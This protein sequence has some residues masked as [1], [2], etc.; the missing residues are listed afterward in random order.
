[1][2]KTF[3][4]GLKPANFQ[5]VFKFSLFWEILPVMQQCQYGDL[6]FQLAAVLKPNVSTPL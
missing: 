3:G 4:Y 2:Y 6:Q 5:T 1:M